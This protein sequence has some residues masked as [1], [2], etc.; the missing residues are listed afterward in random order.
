MRQNDH[1]NQNKDDYFVFHGQNKLLKV[2][3]SLSIAVPVRINQ[4]LVADP[5]S[6]TKFPTTHSTNFSLGCGAL[7]SEQ[8]C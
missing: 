8:Q 4:F 2:P 7:T 3:S 5:H 1:D 6:L